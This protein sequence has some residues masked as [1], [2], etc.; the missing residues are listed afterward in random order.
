MK[1]TLSALSL[2]LILTTGA[3]QAK[4]YL[5]L[6]GV[7]AIPTNKLY[8]STLGFGGAIGLE[9]SPA[10]SLELSIRNWSVPVTG[11]TEGFSL[12]KLSV[13]PLELVFRYRLPL[14]P[15]FKLYGDAG[16]G[17]AF[18]S[19]TFDEKLFIDWTA[20]GFTITENADNG[21]AAHLGLG[22]E[23]V[24]TPTV[25]VDFG[26][27]YHFLRTQGAWTIADIA[28]GETQTGTIKD[29]DFDAFTFSLGF[30]I[31]IF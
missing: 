14:S 1:R 27:R 24:L 18:H 31:S 13:L 4:I 10:A 8:G 2:A 17:Y 6:N 20:V 12:G 28:S 26:V 21:L 23:F 15:N 11:S 5:G 9:L 25:D 7:Y 19:F 16:V 30:K 3:A 22:L 29:L